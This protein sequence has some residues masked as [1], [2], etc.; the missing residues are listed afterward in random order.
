[1]N[2]YTKLAKILLKNPPS[3]EGTFLSVYSYTLNLLLNLCTLRLLFEFN[4]RFVK[5][6][7]FVLKKKGK[8]AKGAKHVY[9]ICATATKGRKRTTSKSGFDSK[10]IIRVLKRNIVIRY[11]AGLR[12][13]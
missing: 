3:S 7:F 1:M 6:S 10:G 8:R 9:S 11:A 5:S 4:F 2:L 13:A 12:N